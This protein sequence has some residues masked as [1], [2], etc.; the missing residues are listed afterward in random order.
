MDIYLPPSPHRSH[1]CP[2]P[3]TCCRYLGLDA[4]GGKVDV[5]IAVPYAIALT[6]PAG[7]DSL[8]LMRLNHNTSSLEVACASNVYVPQTFVTV[9]LLLAPYS[10]IRGCVVKS[11]HKNPNNKSTPCRTASVMQSVLEAMVC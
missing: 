10:F 2:H 8:R 4:G 5:T 6:V 9:G 3:L 7:E 1:A 11:L